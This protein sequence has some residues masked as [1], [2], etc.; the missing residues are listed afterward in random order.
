MW[1]HRTRIVTSL[2]LLV[3]SLG[4]TQAFAARGAE[5]R[6]FSDWLSA[7]GSHK[8]VVGAPLLDGFIQTASGTILG[9]VDYSGLQSQWSADHGG[10]IVN[11][12]I[13]GS[14][15]ERTLPNGSAAI[16]VE[17]DF[18]NA[19]TRAIDLTIGQTVF[20][21]T[22]GQVVGNPSLTPALSSGHMSVKFINPF[23]GAPLPD[24]IDIFT[25]TSLGFHSDGFGPLRASFGVPEGTPGEL[26]L[27]QTGL[28]ALPVVKGDNGDGFAVEKV[29]LTVVPTLQAP[30]S[31][32]ALA[33][34][35]QHTATAST[36]GR[37]KNLYRQP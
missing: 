5:P 13:T 11:T 34:S 10:P 14:V 4:A 37:L 27:A 8:N 24:L 35:P 32:P 30:A 33:S 21:Y 12:V 20:G 29:S 3:A 26:L 1:P 9:V 2:V 28:F 23:P 22:L 19:W 7:Q 17:E 18:T 6:P 36:W 25:L 15:T 16:T 31:S